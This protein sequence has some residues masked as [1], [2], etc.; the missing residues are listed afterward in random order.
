MRLRSSQA[1]RRRAVPEFLNGT[2]ECI[3]A[4]PAATEAP[5]AELVRA[6]ELVAGIVQSVADSVLPLEAANEA[7]ARLRRGEAAGRIVLRVAGA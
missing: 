4:C 1:T 2:A 7:L 3:I 6:I 5:T